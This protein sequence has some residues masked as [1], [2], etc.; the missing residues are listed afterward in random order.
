MKEN[1]KEFFRNLSSGRF[2]KLRTIGLRITST[3]GN[4]C[5]CENAFS[6]MSFMKSRHLNS[7][8]DDSL[9]NLLILYTTKIQVDIQSSVADS[10]RSQCSHE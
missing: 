8:T 5:L 1:G 7:L 2:P 10:G 9:L 6:N 4:T 3:F